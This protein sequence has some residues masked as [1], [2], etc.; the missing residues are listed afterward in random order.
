M[1]MKGK[2]AAALEWAKTWPELDGF[3]KLNA[4]LAQG[5]EAS[6]NTA[7]ST[8][9]IRSY[10]DGTERRQYIFMLK[11]MLPWS[12]GYDPVNVDANAL[13]EKWRDWVDL[14]FPNN[15]PNW[16]CEIESIES[17]YDVPA[18]TVYADDSLA[19]YNFQARI[20]YEE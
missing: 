2:T 6:L 9:V 1:D 7:Y 16:D 11:M 4:I 13:I 15:V 18:I 10:I 20:I 3:L 5:G 14:Q 12:D 8:D 17:L 19:E